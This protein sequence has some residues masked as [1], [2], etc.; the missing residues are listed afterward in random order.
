MFHCL[1]HTLSLLTAEHTNSSVVASHFQY[2]WHLAEAQSNNN[3]PGHLKQNLKSFSVDWCG[4]EVPL[5]HSVFC[6]MVQ[7]KE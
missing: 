1:L 4:C 6:P 2:L 7:L 3:H 5:Y